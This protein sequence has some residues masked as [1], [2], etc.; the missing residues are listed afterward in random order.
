MTFY[1]IKND[2]VCK[3]VVLAHAPNDIQQGISE[4]M[5]PEIKTTAGICAPRGE[6]PSAALARRDKGAIGASAVRM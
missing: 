3:T 1:E 2:V 6:L 5:T 4:A